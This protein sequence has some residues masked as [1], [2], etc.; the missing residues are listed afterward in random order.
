MRQGLCVVAVLALT[1]VDAQ[2]QSGWCSGFRAT[3]FVGP[4]NDTLEV[5]GR[6]ETALFGSAM[7]GAQY[8]NTCAWPWYQEANGW[9]EG[10]QPNRPSA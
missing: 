10:R 4:V 3:Y 5:S 2:A 1:V 7:S 8:G 9:V 6:S